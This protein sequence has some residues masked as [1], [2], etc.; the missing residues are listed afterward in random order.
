MNAIAKMKPI[1]CFWGDGYKLRVHFIV[2][3]SECGVPL[4]INRMCKK[5]CILPSKAKSVNHSCFASDIFVASSIQPNTRWMTWASKHFLAPWLIFSPL[6]VSLDLFYSTD[7]LRR[8]QL[9][10]HISWFAQNILFFHHILEQFGT[11]MIG[12][13]CASMIS[14]SFQFNSFQSYEITAFFSQWYHFQLAVFHNGIRS[15]L[16]LGLERA[17]IDSWT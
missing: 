10:Q 4:K 1:N 11:S 3:W 16:I 14:K 17:Q 15:T 13:S 5:V 12:T 9:F 2:I 6:C 7:K 8:L